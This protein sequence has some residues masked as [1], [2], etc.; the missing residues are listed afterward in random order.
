DPGGAVG[1]VHVPA[2]AEEPVHQQVRV[3]R[4]TSFDAI[5]CT[6]IRPVLP[7]PSAGDPP[8]RPRRR[9]VPCPVPPGDRAGDHRRTGPGICRAADP[10]GR[11]RH[12]DRPVPATTGMSSAPDSVRQPLPP[13]AKAELP[14]R[15]LY[16]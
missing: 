5:P 12:R 11:V 9:R 16:P 4:P 15:V 13:R 7:S 10:P 8:V 2:A 6:L 1:A 3:T 14:A